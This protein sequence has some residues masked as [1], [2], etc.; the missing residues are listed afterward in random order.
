MPG[1]EQLDALA[2][3]FGVPAGAL[4][5]EL[6]STLDPARTQGEHD[7][8]A[9]YRALNTTPAGRA[10]RS[11]AQHGRHQPAPA[12]ARRPQVDERSSSARTT[13]R[14]CEPLQV[15]LVDD[16]ALAQA[17]RQA[18][19]RAVRGPRHRRQGRR[20]RRDRRAPQSAPVPRRRAAQAERA[21]E[22]RSGISSATSPHL[23]GAGRD[24]PVRPQLVQ[25]RRRRAGDGLRH[26]DAGRGLPARRRRRSRSMLVDD[27]ILLFKYWLCCDQDAA[28]G[29]LRRTP[30]TIRSSAGSCRRSISRRASNYDDYT[31]RARRCSRPRTP[32]TRR[33]RWSISTT[34]SAAG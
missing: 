4:L 33:G 29:A 7:L 1:K 8:L 5:A 19:G 34:R 12:R 23:P 3:T 27:G 31:R 30:A 11:R 21:R 25:P 22:R 14:C 2:R 16:G 24:R 26:A 10:A 6:A 18:P 13:R 28:G 15:E 32:S 9:A 17:H 20:D